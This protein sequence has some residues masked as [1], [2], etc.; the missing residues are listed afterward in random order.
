M[1][2]V[3]RILIA[4]VACLPLLV[5]TEDSRFTEVTIERQEIANGIYMISGSGGNI[6]VSAG[7]DG[8]LLIDDQFAPLSHKIKKALVDLS[9]NPVKYVVNT[10]AHAD[11]VGG[12]ENFGKTA[13]IFA[14]H[15]VFYRLSKDKELPKQA[16]PVVT[17]AEG[18]RFHFNDITLD[19]QH[20]ADGHTDGDS[21]V[22]FRESKVLHMGDLFFN[23]MF[24]FIDTQRGGTLDGYIKN[25]K[26]IYEQV[27]EDTQIIPGHGPL[28]EKSDLEQFITMLDNSVI[29]MTHQKKLG[30]DLNA[31]KASMLPKELEDWGWQFVTN[32]RWIE[33]LYNGLPESA[34]N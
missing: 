13:T 9:P 12:N 7:E 22:W 3:I 11:H 8:I 5:L 10:H 28:G 16:L 15:E 14:H 31:I 1:Q 17:Y 24:P 23:G 29:W 26:R 19:V 33:T 27:N 18:I 25:V 30:K 4:V 6:G 2:I 21:V 34:S 32:E 20:L